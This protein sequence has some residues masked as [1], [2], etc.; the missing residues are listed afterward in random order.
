[1][2]NS[3][4]LTKFKDLYN[5]GTD[6]VYR[7][8]IDYVR[9]P[10]E[11]IRRIIRWIPFLWTIRDFDYS[12]SLQVYEFHLRDLE[13]CIANGYHVRGKDV[14]KKVKMLR[15]LLKR[16][17]DTNNYINWDKVEITNDMFSKSYD[18]TKR[19]GIKYNVELG[20]KN[21]HK[22]EEQQY[23]QDMELFCKIHKKYL[24]HFWD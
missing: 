4:N 6:F 18:P 10:C 16:M 15:G 2:A 1:M 19:I 13:K 8:Y 3:L 20:E 5:D 14:A 21:L 17:Q 9:V 11:S 24:R 22:Y 7:R 12:Y 23:Q